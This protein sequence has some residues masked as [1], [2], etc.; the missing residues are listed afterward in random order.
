MRGARGVG[1]GGEEGSLLAT[2]TNPGLA[3]PTYTQF[4]GAPCGRRQEAKGR[5]SVS[6]DA[7]QLSPWCCDLGLQ[8]DREIL[9]IRAHT[10]GQTKKPQ[11]NPT[12]P[13]SWVVARGTAGGWGLRKTCIDRGGPPIAVSALKI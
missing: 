10:V 3:L 5:E 7:T 1:L 13:R 8:D 6:I 9:S 11:I 2:N 4:G 12:C